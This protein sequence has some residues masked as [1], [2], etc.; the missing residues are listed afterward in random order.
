MTFSF[1]IALL[2]PFITQTTAQVFH[3][4]HSSLSA[5]SSG[6]SSP[7]SPYQIMTHAP[8]LPSP[9]VQAQLTEWE[10]HVSQ[11]KVALDKFNRGKKNRFSLSQGSGAV[12]IRCGTETLPL[13]TITAIRTARLF[14]PFA[15][16]YDAFVRLFD[17]NLEACEGMT[18]PE[19]QALFGSSG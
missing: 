16:D 13:H 1:I 4:K 7:Y 5:S 6:G 17:A 2:A 12:K 10:I 18:T 9:L 8:P 15:E 14:I 19:V 11:L 3:R